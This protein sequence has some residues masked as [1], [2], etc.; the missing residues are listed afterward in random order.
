V[1]LVAEPLRAGNADSFARTTAA[2]LTSVDNFIG[3]D[4][5]RRRD[6]V[7]ASRF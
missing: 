7:G 4:E 3:T 2:K 5:D 6:R 1:L